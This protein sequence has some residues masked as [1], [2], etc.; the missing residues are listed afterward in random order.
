MLGSIIMVS[1]IGAVI[2]NV[3]GYSTAT[4]RKNEGYSILK[5]GRTLAAGAI[6]A[7][8]CA[9]VCMVLT[10][11]AVVA[12]PETI[13]NGIMVGIAGAYGIDKALKFVGVK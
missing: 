3:I 11:S 10:D 12:M 8:V 9:V 5:G 7:A 1:I 13:W 4:D 2:Y 6:Q